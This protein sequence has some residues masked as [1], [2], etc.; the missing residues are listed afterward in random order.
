M[1]LY[2]YYF[3]LLLS[4]LIDFLHYYY[5]DIFIIW[6]SLCHFTFSSMLYCLLRFFTLFLSIMPL[7][8]LFRL[9]L[10]RYLLIFA[11]HLFDYCFRPLLP[12][13]SLLLFLYFFRHF[14][15]IFLFLFLFR[16]SPLIFHWFSPP[17][18]IITFHI[19][20]F[21]LIIYFHLFLSIIFFL[22]LIFAFRQMPF[23]TFSMSFLLSFFRFS[24]SLHFRH[25]LLSFFALLLMMPIF[26]PLLFDAIIALLFSLYFH[27]HIFYAIIDYALFIFFYLII[28][29]LLF[30][31]HFFALLL[32]RLLPIIDDYFL[33]QILY[34]SLL[35]WLFHYLFS[36]VIIFSG[37]Y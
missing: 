2:C 28:S 17:L 34:I 10:F 9:T 30:R 26:S 32:P 21:I 15:F 37:L 7:L 29:C 35:D 3:H 20:P 16:A 27:F 6:F 25:W 19:S 11:R 36:L 24:I 23:M 1:P 13:I 33:R 5:I 22:L 18:F 8:T 14:D 4:R 31:R 12:A